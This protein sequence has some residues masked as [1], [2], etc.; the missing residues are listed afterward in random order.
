MV[1]RRHSHI[2]AERGIRIIER[3]DRMVEA[4]RLTDEEATRLRAAGG[5]GELDDAVREIQLKHARARVRAAV[6]EGSLTDDEAQVM[7]ERLQE[8]EDPRFL[9]GLR[10]GTRRRTGADG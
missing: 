3:L 1:H 8:G 4:G 10:R 7:L 9:R 6:D 2:S 5:A